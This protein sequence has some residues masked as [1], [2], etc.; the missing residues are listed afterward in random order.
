MAGIRH[1]VLR[2]AP[3]ERGVAHGEQARA[4]I[5]A[6][7]DD[8]LARLNHLSPSARSLADLTPELHAYGH[9]I[10]RQLPDLFREIEGL[11]EGASIPLEAAILLQTRRELMGYSRIPAA[12]DCTTFATCRTSS[13]TL[14]QTVDVNGDLDRELCLLDVESDRPDGRALV[15]SFT[16]L[17]GYLGVNAAG[18]AVGL[19][20]VLGGDWQAGVPPYL[21]IRHLLD[22]ATD[23]ED[24]IDRLQHLELASSRSFM[25]CDQWQ[26]AWVEALGGRYAVTRGQKLAHANHFLDPDFATEDEINVFARNSSLARL[27][28][29]EDW[30]AKAPRTL[31]ERAVFDLLSRPPICV[32]GSDDIRREK[33]VAAVVM[34]PTEG[35][36][37]L[38]PG[39]PSTSR[40]RTFSLRTPSGRPES[41]PS[42]AAASVGEPA[43]AGAGGKGRMCHV[44]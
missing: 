28:A 44:V 2:G 19:N 6:F 27:R 15:F 12:G 18:L 34:R 13:P 40:E 33:T 41:E 20:L 36:L 8:G 10:E 25:L 16:G 17:L 23:V 26:V 22:R 43:H 38:R 35:V 31:D 30:L 7:L 42:I 4:A 9:A 11:A 39:D 1:I 24:A 14:A 5:H 37:S 32:P 3:F 21:A 29:C